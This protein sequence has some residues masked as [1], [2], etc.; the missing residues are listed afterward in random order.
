MRTTS[1]VLLSLLSMVLCCVS[2]AAVP[3][4]TITDLGTLYG[5][6]SYGT[7]INNLGQAVGYSSNQDGDFRA[8][9]YTPG[10]GL[11]DLD[12]LGGYAAIAYGINDSGQVVG[13]SGTNGLGDR[14]FIYTEQAGMCDLGVPPPNAAGAGSSMARAISSSGHVAGFA[15]NPADFAQHAFLLGPSG[16]ADLGTLGGSESYGCAVNS[17]GQVVGQSETASGGTHAFVYTPGAGM[18]SLGLLQNGIYS[19]ATGINESGWV[20]GYCWTSQ[21]QNR[22]FV[23]VPGTGMSDLGTLGTNGAQAYGINAAG[24]I[25]GDL[26]LGGQTRAFVYET[27]GSMVQLP[28]LGGSQSMARGI[29]DLDQVVG[30][31]T[32]AQGVY[33]AVIWTPV[34]EPTPTTA[35]RMVIC[36]RTLNPKSNGKWISCWIKVTSGGQTVRDID[37]KS[38]RLQEKLPPVGR[39][40]ICDPDRDGVPEMVVTFD[41]SALLKTLVPG[42]QAVKLTGAFKD[43]A[44]FEA[45]ATVR[46]LNPPP[47][48]RR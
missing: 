10:K 36:P 5:L 16:F 1:L 12:T 11:K 25:V 7:G 23:Y 4:Y 20:V 33:H 47:P 46:V 6:D 26:D 43:G 39:C 2:Y 22:A 44:S 42:K 24:L 32:T 30:F 45:A 35:V 21:N 34:I 3:G 17:C 31:A 41:R 29:N 13:Y 9:L 40:C 37:V 14:A 19:V 8:F 38:L 27:G 48:K 28:T 18:A 15:Q